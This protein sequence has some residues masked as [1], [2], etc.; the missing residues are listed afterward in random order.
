MIETFE[1]TK[2]D[3]ATSERKVIPIHKP[4][5]MMLAL[6]VSEFPLEEQEIYAE[7]VLEAQEAFKEMI[8]NAG[9]G[10]QYRYFKKEGIKYFDS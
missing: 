1:Y 7:A 2:A 6:D 5:E 3:G 9:L 10:S 8:K 4:S